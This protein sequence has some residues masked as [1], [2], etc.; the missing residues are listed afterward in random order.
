MRH[1]FLIALLTTPLTI[2]NSFGQQGST[3]DNSV[4]PPVF[5]TVNQRI[6]SAAEYDQ[7]AKETFRKKFYHGAPPEAEVNEMLRS[8]GQTLIDDLLLEE[9]VNKRNTPPDIDSVDKEIARYEAKYSKSAVWA[10]QRD[11]V[12]PKLR[13]HLEKK[14]KRD[15]LE[16]QI[17]AVDIPAKAVQKFY[18]DNPALFTEPEKNKVSIILLPVSPSAAPEVWE[19]TENDA[20]KLLLEIK[21]GTSFEKI[22]KEK[23]GDASSANGGDLG[24]VHGGMLSDNVEAELS[25]LKIGEIGGPVTTLEG[26][27]IFRLDNRMPAKLRKFEDVQSRARDLLLREE[28][29]RAWTDFLAKLRKQAKVEIDPAFKNVMEGKGIA[30]KT[31]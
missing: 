3:Q 15:N 10:S 23:S 6:L 18:Y 21:Q 29:E 12:L 30:A 16:K 8:V 24:Y 13:A 5:A 19:T 17:R 27:T 2:G 20:K 26:V 22:A 11:E 7:N 25:K 4:A 28:S 9:E 1:S 14:S 31:P